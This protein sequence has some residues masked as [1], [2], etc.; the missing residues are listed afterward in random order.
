[1]WSHHAEYEYEYEVVRW[2]WLWDRT[3]I[4]YWRW[5]Y[6]T[7]S[8]QL[9]LSKCWEYGAWGI[10]HPD[11]KSIGFIHSSQGKCWYFG[12]YLFCGCPLV[13]LQRLVQNTCLRCALEAVATIV[14]FSRSQACKSLSKFQSIWT[15]SCVNFDHTL[16]TWS[17]SSTTQGR[18]SDH[19]DMNGPKTYRGH[20]TWSRISYSQTRWRTSWQ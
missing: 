2:L 14:A 15:E 11:P 16:W 17:F 7:C 8:A 10:E 1:M 20:H 3:S 4:S 9:L 13:L 6:P 5:G 19:V 18:K 12:T